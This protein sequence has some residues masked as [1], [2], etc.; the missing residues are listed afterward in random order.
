MVTAPASM[1]SPAAL[2]ALTFS[3]PTVL[4]SSST[5]LAALACAARSAEG[6][7][8]RS[9][10]LTSVH[11]SRSSAIAKNFWRRASCSACLADASTSALRRSSMCSTDSSHLDW[12]SSIVIEP[13]ASPALSRSAASFFTSSKALVCGS[14]VATASSKSACCSCAPSTVVSSASGS[15]VASRSWSSHELSDA[16]LDV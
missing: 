12:R 13:S 2:S 1:A 5:P 3:R 11:A 4:A 6:V 10:I 14:R 8:A 9:A 15:E 7:P 16:A